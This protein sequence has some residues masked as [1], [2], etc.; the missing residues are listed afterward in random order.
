M[1]QVIRLVHQQIG[2]DG[3]AKARAEYAAVKTQIEATGESFAKGE[4]TAAQLDKATGALSREFEKLGGFLKRLDDDMAAQAAEA[5][6]GTAATQA[7]AAAATSASA[8]GSG[9]GAVMASASAAAA[10]A[11]AKTAQAAAAA[12]QAE[13]AFLA[14]SLGLKQATNAG[15]EFAESAAHAAASEYELA[16]S[17]VIVSAKAAQSKPGLS[18]VDAA[19]EEIASSS[20]RAAGSLGKV[21]TAASSV[22]VGAGQLGVGITAAGYAFQD[23]TSTSG[24]L[25][26][27]LNSITNNLPQLIAGLGFGG[28]LGAGVAALG[29]GAIVLY[30]NWDSVSGLW[31]NRRPIEGAIQGVDQLSKAVEKNKTALDALREQGDLN[32][33]QWGEFK[34]LTEE[35]AVAEAALA[36]AR[37]TEANKKAHTESSGERDKQLGGAVGKALDT[38]GGFEVVVKEFVDAYLESSGQEDD[39]KAR[40]DNTE[41]FSKLM[42]RALKGDKKAIA[43]LKG[44]SDR[45]KTGSIGAFSGLVETFDPQTEQTRKNAEKA[46]KDKADAGKKAEKAEDDFWSGVR[47]QDREEAAELGRHV[48]ELLDDVG[49]ELKATAEAAAKSGKGKAEIAAALTPAARKAAGDLKL[50]GDDPD[51]VAAAA[52]DQVADDATDSRA[53]ARRQRDADRT[54]KKDDKTKDVEAAKDQKAL[55]EGLGDDFLGDAEAERMGL[56]LDPDATAKMQAD[57]RLRLN[58]L[59]ITRLKAAGHS[60]DEAT[61]L[62]GGAGTLVDSDV[63]QRMNQARAD[64]NAPDAPASLAMQ[65]AYQRLMAE[66]S[67]RRPEPGPK[68]RP[69]AAPLKL[70]RRGRPGVG[71]AAA[72]PKPVVSITPDAIKSRKKVSPKAAAV[73]PPTSVPP[74]LGPAFGAA[75]SRLPGQRPTAPKPDPTAALATTQAAMAETQRAAQQTINGLARLKQQADM[76]QANAR[77]LNRGASGLNQSRQSMG[78]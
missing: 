31:E 38:A 61:R 7:W 22:R 71:P 34:R 62:A 76:L 64:N 53:R 11:S 32:I 16:G 28:P 27:K 2:A 39:E 42:N 21:G 49:Q 33:R 18:A 20:T 69:V 55:A 73:K 5:A 24:D 75:P 37:E 72:R 66:R 15:Y 65:A 29:V 14:E 45:D 70:K 46:T 40:A 58:Q 43:S 48:K 51:D 54:G 26:A 50:D 68:A 47:A 56:A 44:D 12:R 9:W 57:F 36:D 19:M 23:F 3:V 17:V 67:S 6:K 78:T 63:Q 1:D 4:I 59:A 8:A 52:A 30:R 13:A 60:L 25:G 77:D 10:E 35:Q 74:G 41:V